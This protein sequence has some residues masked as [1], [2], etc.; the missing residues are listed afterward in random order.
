MI[1]LLHFAISTN[2]NR[3]QAQMFSDEDYTLAKM[4]ILMRL[5]EPFCGPGMTRVETPWSG[6]H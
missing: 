6:K 4:Y 3:K 2:P 1:G 5:D